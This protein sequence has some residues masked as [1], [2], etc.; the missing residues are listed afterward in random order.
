MRRKFLHL[1]NCLISTNSF[2]LWACLILPGPQT[3]VSKPISLKMPASVPKLTAEV[4]FFLSACRHN[5]IKLEELSVKRGGKLFLTYNSIL[6]F[7]T[8]F[9]ISNSNSFRNFFILFINNLLSISGVSLISN[10][11]THLFGII[12][13]AKP[14]FIFP[15]FKVG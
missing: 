12:F 5:D 2:G 1:S 8:F 10:S 14:P 11:I 7:L 9:F 6:Q 13:T 15:T 4:E 3:I